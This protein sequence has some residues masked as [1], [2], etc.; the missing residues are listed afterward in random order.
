MIRT[1]LPRGWCERKSIESELNRISAR[2]DGLKK[3]IIYAVGM[4]FG[5]PT[6]G[7]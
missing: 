4:G 6:G 5:V 3:K 2:M 1:D 7:E